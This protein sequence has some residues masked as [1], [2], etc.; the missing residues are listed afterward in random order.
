MGSVDVNSFVNQDH[1]FN[2]DYYGFQYIPEQILAEAEKKIIENDLV[3][4]KKLLEDI[5]VQVNPTK[6][7]KIIEK[8]KYLLA[9]LLYFCSVKEGNN[10]QR[11]IELYAE[12]SNS[13]KS[14]ELVTKAKLALGI[15]YYREDSI[16]KDWQLSMHYFKEVSN[17]Y[18]ADPETRILANFHQAEILRLGNES[19]QKNW[20][21]SARLYREVI[22][23][24]PAEKTFDIKFTLACMLISSNYGLEPC[25]EESVSLLKDI[26][27]KSKDVAVSNKAK[28]ELAKI[29]IAFK[30][31]LDDD[32]SKSIQLLNEIIISSDR[33][34][35]LMAVAKL[36]LI[37]IYII[38]N[39]FKSADELINEITSDKNLKTKYILQAYQFKL[40]LLKP[41]NS[42]KEDFLTTLFKIYLLSDAEGRVSIEEK[43]NNSPFTKNNFDFLLAIQAYYQAV[44]DFR[45][46]ISEVPV[47]PNSFGTLEDFFIKFSMTNDS[48]ELEKMK[49]IIVDLVKYDCPINNYF[50]PNPPNHNY[51]AN[52]FIIEAGKL[53]PKLSQ[54]EINV[55]NA[56]LAIKFLN[57][58]SKYASAFP[59]AFYN[60]TL[61][62][63]HLRLKETGSKLEAYNSVILDLQEAQKYGNLFISLLEQGNKWKTLALKELPSLK[64]QNKKFRMSTVDDL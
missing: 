23:Q 10:V 54:K 8:A 30:K 11:A 52:L 14:D 39:N 22:N 46:F 58:V 35:D 57:E 24:Y 37:D 43:L 9:D 27:G 3:S 2:F 53:V 64:R 45:Y 40:Y 20:Q 21:E 38:Q 34:S 32:F 42:S 56:K 5:I 44:N 15:I 59:Q 49:S 60:K 61:I 28:Y 13:S 51:L 6:D 63:Y 17:N 4:A 36:S 16:E 47:W 31:D 29:Y 41:E 7:Q 48:K 55:E 1:F 18:L 50:N 25:I 12:I 19:I 62:K 33:D 26:I